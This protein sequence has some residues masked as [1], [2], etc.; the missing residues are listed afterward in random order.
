MVLNQVSVVGLILYGPLL[1]LPVL[2]FTRGLNAQSFT[3]PKR[4]LWN[5]VETFQ[6]KSKSRFDRKRDTA[7]TVCSHLHPETLLG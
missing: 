1:L 2:I 3:E 5:D 7:G 4:T 6:L